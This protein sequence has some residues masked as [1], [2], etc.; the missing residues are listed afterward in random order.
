MFIIQI[1]RE[2]CVD[3]RKLKKRCLMEQFKE[4]AVTDLK[5]LF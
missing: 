4:K 1:F 2:Y 5:E 3:I